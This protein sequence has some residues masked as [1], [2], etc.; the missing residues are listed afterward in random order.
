MKKPHNLET[1]QGAL[2][3]Q[4]PGLTITTD[5]FEELL[6]SATS[7]K[8]CKKCGERVFFWGDSISEDMPLNWT[9]PYCN[10]YILGTFY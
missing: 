2:Q 1:I 9:C 7:S 10:K 5:T 8:S 6:L 4:Y 3:F